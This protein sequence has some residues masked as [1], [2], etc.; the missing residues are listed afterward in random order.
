MQRGKEKNAVFIKFPRYSYVPDCITHDPICE[1]ATQRLK[2]SER[3]QKNSE[4]INGKGI[5]AATKKKKTT[6]FSSF[7][8]VA[9]PFT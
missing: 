4:M 5:V 3:K 2:C 9:L 1:S 8:V 7:L 6:E